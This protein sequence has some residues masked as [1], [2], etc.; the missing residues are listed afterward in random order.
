MCG[1]IHCSTFLCVLLSDT[2]MCNHTCLRCVTR[3][4]AAPVFWPMTCV[5]AYIK[6][7]TCVFCR[8]PCVTTSI[9][10]PT[11]MFCCLTCV[12]ISTGTP[13]CVFCRLTSVTISIIAAFF[14]CLVI[15]VHTA[16]FYTHTSRA[17]GKLG[18]RPWTK[19]YKHENKGKSKLAN[20]T[21][22][23]N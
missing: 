8:L 17:R 13:T 14:A 15:H 23:F 9:R 1:H 16:C 20:L 4:T 10:A 11:C 2:C 7:P 21:Y 3:S 6:A 12:T 5:S 22:Y 18:A 19:E